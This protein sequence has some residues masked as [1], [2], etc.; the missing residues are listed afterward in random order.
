MSGKSEE[1]EIRLATTDAAIRRLRNSS[2]LAS[3]AVSSARTSR[4]TSVYWDTPALDLRA[5]RLALRL[6]R[7]DHC[8]W[9]QALKAETQDPQSRKEYEGAVSGARPELGLAHRLG[10]KRDERLLALDNELKPIFC[11]RVMR[12]MRTVRFDDGTVAELSVDRGE[13]SADLAQSKPER[14]LEIEIELVAGSALRLYELACQ[15]VRELP[16]TRVLFASKARRGYELLTSAPTPPRRAME[17][18]IPRKST[19][20]LVAFRAAAESLVQV[21]NNVESARSGND[22]EGV[23]QMRIGVR[24]LRVTDAIAREAGL[25]SFSDKLGEELKWLWR[26]LGES[27]DWDVFQMETWPAVERAA[28]NGAATPSAFDASVSAFREASHRKLRRALD[29]R[30][31]QVIVLALGWLN[32]LQREEIASARRHTSK[33]VARQLLSSRAKRMS[34]HG[35]DIGRL[36]DDQRHQ[37]RIDA[38]K[39]RY[40]AEFFSGLYPSQATRR[41]L[42]RL[43]AVQSALGDLNDTAVTGQIVRSATAAA[44]AGER[45]LVIDMWVGYASA[46]E[47]TLRDQLVERWNTFTNTRPFWE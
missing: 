17:I 9:I 30:R 42:R 46:S 19:A 13:L 31:F 11:T 44:P 29:G 39:L 43:A 37:L 24:R 7:N 14:I 40:L 1:I 16:S 33:H 47:A 38:K 22:P 28:C 21:Q 2:V 5:S 18:D 34:G 3:L 15:L 41:Y 35:A 23:H 12:T 36:A 27:R 25:S 10:W 4:L 45:G 8:G 6:R 26:L 20:A 32:T